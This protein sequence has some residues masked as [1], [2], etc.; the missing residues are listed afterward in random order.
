[1]FEIGNSLREARLRQA[2]DFPEL[3]QATKIRGKYLRALEDEQFEV[4]PA[5]TYV[6]GFL[7]TYAEFLGLD[8]QLYVDEYNSRYVVDDETLRPRRAAS[9]RVRQQRRVES[10]VVV[11]ALLGI[12]AVTA[13]VLLAWRYTGGNGTTILPTVSAPAPTAAATPP[14]L[15]LRGV[16]G[17]SF[18][19]VRA[20]SATGRILFSGTLARGDVQRFT[21][22]RLWVQIARPRNLRIVVRGK[23][24]PR[25]AGGTLTAVVA[26]GRL[27]PVAAS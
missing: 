5:Q 13:L 16:R 20:G 6:R 15:S 9:Q 3:E 1:V 25:R 12:A 26:H 19:R 11:L 8:G 27:V 21:E 14:L 22:P 23:T 7:R 24:L 10:R 4:L 17:P 18:V 2:L